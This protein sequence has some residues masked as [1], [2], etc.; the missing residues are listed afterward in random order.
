MHIYLTSK[1]KQQNF[2]KIVLTLLR[3]QEEQSINVL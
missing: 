3:V 2:E 1:K